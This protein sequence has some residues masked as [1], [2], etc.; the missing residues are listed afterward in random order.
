MKT[1]LLV[2][3]HRYALLERRQTY[4]SSGKAVPY[5]EHCASFLGENNA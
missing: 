2:E 3:Q 4:Q 1:C 5:V